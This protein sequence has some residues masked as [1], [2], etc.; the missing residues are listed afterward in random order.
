MSRYILIL[1]LAIAFVGCENNS[2]KLPV[3]M[4]Q[5]PNTAEGL[6]KNSPTPLVVF[7]KTTHDFGELIQGEIVS[8]NF[9][10]TNTGNADLIISEVSSSCGCTVSEYPLDAIKPGDTKSI[11]AIFDSESRIGFQ[12]K[13]ITVLTNATPAKYTLYIKA[14]IS[15]PGQ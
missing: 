13:R 5:N 9:S 12:N 14:E 11:K 4:I 6:D 3:D 15:K 7:N 10:F 1:M 8:Y 2:D